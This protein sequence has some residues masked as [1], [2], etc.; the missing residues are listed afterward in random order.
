MPEEKMNITSPFSS[1]LQEIIGG[2]DILIEVARDLIKDE[3][4]ARVKEIIRNDPALEKELK[5]AVGMYFE[6]KVKETYAGLK[7]AK[8]GAK[9][10]LEMLPDHL[11]K[12]LSK[13]I[14]TEV[15]QLLERALR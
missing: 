10:T 12:D 5:D 14:E 15:A 8:S 7:I 3:I 1:T 9:L 6:A 11:K 13:D 4:K 2:E